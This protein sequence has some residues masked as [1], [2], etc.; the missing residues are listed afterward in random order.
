MITELQ[1]QDT[2]QTLEFKIDYKLQQLKANVSAQINKRQ[3][4]VI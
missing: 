2:E 1:L 4:T 3:V